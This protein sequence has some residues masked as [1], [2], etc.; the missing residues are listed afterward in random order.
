MTDNQQRLYQD[1]AWM[2]PII[3]PLRDYETESED[4]TRV[5]HQVARRP[6]KTLLHLGCGGGHH[7]FIFAR[8]FAVT[9][10]D[11]SEPMLA[12]AR[13]LNP[14]VTYIA[15]DMR[16]VRLGQSFDAV[17]I[18]DSIDYMLNQRDLRAAFRTAFEH[19]APGGVFVTYAEIDR[20]HF[21]PNQSFV[22]TEKQ[23]DVE[24]TILRNHYDPDPSDT[25]IEMTFVY[26]IRRGGKLTI[27]TDRH[28]A[29]IF[30]LAT[31]K[32]LLDE[33]GF[34]VHALENEFGEPLF[35]GVRPLASKATL[36]AWEKVSKTQKRLN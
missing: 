8:H 23:G 27:E 2:W 13:A 6:I 14:Q 7:D 25:T 36:Q 26:L 28:L 4:L 15:G 34:E 31:W 19:L 18:A 35:A 16:T 17:V 33:V 12:L 9:G 1:L 29:G 30:P 24:I 5:I 10:V 32:R 20:E 21:V 3:S 22:S 11:L